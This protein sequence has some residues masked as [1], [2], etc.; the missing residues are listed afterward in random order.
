MR[1][2]EQLK[3]QH[4]KFNIAVGINSQLNNSSS[5]AL[6][7]NNSK[8]KTPNSFKGNGIAAIPLKSLELRHGTARG[9][10]HNQFNH[11]Q[12]IECYTFPVDLHT[13][14]L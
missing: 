6:A 8:F 13:R 4:S 7:A 5:H 14:S 1:S 10:R 9:A 2:S 11:S 3:I 12:H